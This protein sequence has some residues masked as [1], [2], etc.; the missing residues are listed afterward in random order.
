MNSQA[1]SQ[2][3]KKMVLNSVQEKQVLKNI[4]GGDVFD[5][6]E[7]GP[8]FCM[9]TTRLGR[10]GVACNPA[11]W[12]KVH[13]GVSESTVLLCTLSRLVLGPL[14]NTFRR[15]HKLYSCTRDCTCRPAAVAITLPAAGSSETQTV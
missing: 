14:F 13:S 4:P 15:M 7:P 2:K 9:G 3:F 12:Y 1:D 6:S 10:L 11:T 8:F 5:R